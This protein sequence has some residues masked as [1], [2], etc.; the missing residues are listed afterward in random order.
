[1]RGAA[2]VVLAVTVGMVTGCS[3]DDEL[4]AVE[5]ALPPLVLAAETGRSPDPSKFWGS[6]DC[7][8]D[9]DPVQRSGAV[10]LKTGGDVV[11]AAGG[12]F[13]GDKAFRR[14]TTFDGDDFYGERCELGLNDDEGPTAFY[15]EG[16]RRVTYASFRLPDNY[17]LETDEWQG[18]LQMKQAQQADNADGTPVL[19]VSAFRGQWSLWHSDAGYTN[20]DFELWA[21]P[22]A[23]NVWTAVAMDVIYSQ[24]PER[25]RV[26]LY[27]DSNGDG[28]FDDEGE[29][30][31]Q[32]ATNTLKREDGTDGSDGYSAGDSIPSHLRVGLYHDAVI[33]C[34]PPAGCSLDVDSVL[35]VRPASL[36]AAVPGLG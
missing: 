4:G 18:V 2:A 30:S 13:N 8:L 16:E 25:G 20:E 15:R 27:V 3:A 23:K 9:G 32:F 11:S 29:S 26:R 10:R 36:E 22:A 19:S 14:L 17:P 33:P 31:P 6:V 12:V 21:T 7:D 24:D 1:M 35:V 28:E 34:P 5:V